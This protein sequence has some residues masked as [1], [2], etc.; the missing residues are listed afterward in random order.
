[1]NRW[2]K[3]DVGDIYGDRSRS[4]VNHQ[5]RTNLASNL[6]LI[7]QTKH[8][9]SDVRIIAKA[10]RASN[11][12][13]KSL[14]HRH[15]PEIFQKE[16]QKVRAE[17]EGRGAVTSEADY[18]IIALK[19]RLK[20][21][22]EKVAR[23]GAL[24]SRE[25]HLRDEILSHI[26]FRQGGATKVRQAVTPKHIDRAVVGARRSA[27]AGNNTHTTHVDAASDTTSEEPFIPSNIIAGTL[28]RY[29]KYRNSIAHKQRQS[30]QSVSSSR[31][32]RRS[33]LLQV[34]VKTQPAG[35]GLHPARR[36]NGARSGR[37]LLLRNAPREEYY[38]EGEHVDAIFCPPAQ[39]RAS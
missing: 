19:S 17:W 16:L 22:K 4:A 35:A 38:E 6:T 8:M 12:L 21:A 5:L 37:P 33:E 13:T 24:E 15:Q 39:S 27:L 30:P 34:S 10:C 29:R 25:D 31:R 2:V 26:A 32:A 3:M 20:L 7:Q 23:L 36:A 1:M 11:Q 9:L 18:Q 28:S 14:K